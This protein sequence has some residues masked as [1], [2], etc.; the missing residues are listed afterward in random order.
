MPIPPIKKAIHVCITLMLVSIALLIL[1]SSHQLVAAILPGSLNG[2]ETR[3]QLEPQHLELDN[4]H[5]SPLLITGLFITCKS[6]CPANI[7]QLRLVKNQYQGEMNYVFIGLNPENDSSE[8]LKSYLSEFS[9]NMHLRVPA[10]TQAVQQLMSFFPEN[11]SMSKTNI[12]H[13]GYI[14]LYH[15]NAKGLITYRSPNS[16]HII[17]DLL[18]LQ[19]RGK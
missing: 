16:Q 1:V 9:P 17:D 18:I 8:T 3:I 2:L 10:D 5:P 13:A 14:Y 4:A 11:Y 7:N 6:T 19:S 12:H 15:P